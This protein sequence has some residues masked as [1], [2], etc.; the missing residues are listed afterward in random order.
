MRLFD[1]EGFDSVTV[2]RIAA[3][4]GISA[5]TFFRYFASKEDLLLQYQRAIDERLLGALAARPPCEGAVAA[6]RQAYIATSHVAPEDRRS[7]LLSNRFLC[8]SRALRERAAGERIVHSGPIIRLL[9]ERADLDPSDPRLETIA[10]AIGAVA[11]AAFQR[12]LSTGGLGDPA[13]EVGQAI[14]LIEAG[15]AK[16]DSP[17]RSVE[18]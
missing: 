4:A 7:V 12:W 2:D 9:A 8:S 14:G 1:A 17:A 13:E 6:L 5:R 15:L 10:V 11:G 18:K 16:L 3:E